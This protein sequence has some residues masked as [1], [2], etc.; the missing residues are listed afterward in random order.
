M[1]QSKV[2]AIVLS[3]LLFLP[4]SS[5]AK[6]RSGLILNAEG[7]RE[8]GY[9]YGGNFALY[10]VPHGED[11]G[12]IDDFNHFQGQKRYSLTLDGEAGRIV[13]LYARPHFKGN[14]GFL[15]IR[16]TDDRQ[17]WIQDL[18]DFPK[19]VW[20]SV[21]SQNG[22]GGFEVYSQA[23]PLFDQ[24]ISSVKWGKWWSGEKPQS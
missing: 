8:L 5:G 13:T 17:V 12:R 7:L 2:L 6:G 11:R 14:A 9:S 22:Y 16:K 23:A 24:N 10:D 4:I 3:I 21:P 1:T 19:G 18:M 15:V 20:H